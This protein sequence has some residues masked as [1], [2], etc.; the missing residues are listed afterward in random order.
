M[1]PS[2]TGPQCLGWLEWAT[3]VDSMLPSTGGSQ[4]RCQHDWNA[5]DRCMFGSFLAL[6][7]PFANGCSAAIDWYPEPWWKARFDCVRFAVPTQ[8]PSP[9]S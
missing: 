3:V 7:Y 8:Q 6:A 9:R 4:Q 1:L 5:V 2:P